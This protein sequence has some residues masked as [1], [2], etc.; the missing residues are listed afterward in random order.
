MCMSHSGRVQGGGFASAG[1]EA[2]VVKCGQ[3]GGGC[4]CDDRATYNSACQ[5]R[6]LFVYQP[7]YSIVVLG[8]G[9][10]QG[11]GGLGPGKYENGRTP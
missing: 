11:G 6:E 3:Y 2:I 8:L 10:S 7:R 1:Q 9:R 4:V 5:D